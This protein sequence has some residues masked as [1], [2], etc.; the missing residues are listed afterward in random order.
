LYTYHFHYF[1][2]IWLLFLL[3]VLIILTIDTALLIKECLNFVLHLDVVFALQHSDQPITPCK[4]KCRKQFN[5]TTIT[6]IQRLKLFKQEGSNFNL[7]QQSR[8]RQ[9]MSSRVTCVGFIWPDTEAE[10]AQ[11]F[12]RQLITWKTHALPCSTRLQNLE[13]GSQPSS[14]HIPL[15]RFDR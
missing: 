9:C 3:T 6:P 2:N 4:Q 11:L 1:E 13:Q 7:S 10:N 5:Q 14:G 15:L 8:I 12:I